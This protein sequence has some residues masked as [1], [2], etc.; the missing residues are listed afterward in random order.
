MLQ[1]SRLKGTG[2]W[3]AI[4]VF[5][6]HWHLLGKTSLKKSEKEHQFMCHALQRYRTL[7]Q[8]TIKWLRQPSFGRL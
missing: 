3:W 7:M 4:K 6:I 1:P 2:D 5:N 8:L